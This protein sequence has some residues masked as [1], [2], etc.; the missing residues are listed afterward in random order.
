MA[1]DRENQLLSAHARAIVGDRDQRLATLL[2]DNLDARGAGVDRV[3]DQFLDR[4]RRA[5]DDLARGDAVDQNRREQADRHRRTLLL[6]GGSDET[7]RETP[8]DDGSASL[9]SSNRQR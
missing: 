4:S 7:A 1:L 8:L 3:L 2:E 5:L 6:P 9:W